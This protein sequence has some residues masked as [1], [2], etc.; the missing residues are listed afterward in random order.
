[1]NRSELSKSK[2]KK[3]NAR[4]FAAFARH[5]R[6]FNEIGT[7]SQRLSLSLSGYSSSLKTRKYSRNSAEIKSC[8]LSLDD[9]ASRSAGIKRGNEAE[10]DQSAQTTRGPR[11]SR[12]DGVKIARWWSLTLFI[13]EPWREKSI[14]A[15]RAVAEE[16][17]GDS[18]RDTRI[19]WL[20]SRF[21]FRACELSNFRAANWQVAKRWKLQPV[22]S[23]WEAARWFL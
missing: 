8:L 4:T 7:H 20:R 13:S 1:M 3:S 11:L 19:N 23:R 9:F 22:I 14:T 17:I 5:E 10:L 16:S 6:E 21:S 15:R 12:F 18:E 2:R